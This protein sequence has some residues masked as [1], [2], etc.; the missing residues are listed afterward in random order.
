MAIGMA[1][2]INQNI[3]L[4]THHLLGYGVIIPGAHF[5]P[6][7]GGLFSPLRVHI[8]HAA[9]MVDKYFHAGWVMLFQYWQ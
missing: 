6:Y 8:V 5:S 2:R 7:F 4:I 1:C 3:Q 9:S